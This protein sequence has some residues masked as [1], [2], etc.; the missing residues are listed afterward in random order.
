MKPYVMV[1]RPVSP[2][3]IEMLTS[4]CDIL[5]RVELSRSRRKNFSLI[6][7]STHALLL[8]TPEYVDESLLNKFPQVRAIACTFRMPEHIDVAAC[9]RRGV[10]VTNVSTKWLGAQ[11]EIEAARNILDV[12]SG[13]IPR[14]AMNDV[15]QPA[16]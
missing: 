15:L 7:E 10:W 14:G 12:F 3:A 6:A 11:A 2:A 4:V 1:T 16:A 13:D 5:P 8:A 9:T